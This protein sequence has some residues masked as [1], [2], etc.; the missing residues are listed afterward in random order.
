MNQNLSF[1]LAVT[2]LLLLLS[3][4]S[5]ARGRVE[6]PPLILYPTYEHF[7]SDGGIVYEGN[8]RLIS[9]KDSIFTGDDHYKFKDKIQKRKVKVKASRISGIK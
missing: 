6:Q 8:Y 9:N 3:I 7:V 5:Q 4:S 1:Y 2:V